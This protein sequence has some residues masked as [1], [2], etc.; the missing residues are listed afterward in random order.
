L[1]G[2]GTPVVADLSGEPMRAALAGRVTV[3]KVSQDERVTHCNLSHPS[4]GAVLDAIYELATAGADHVIVSRGDQPALAMLDG[5]LL[6]VAG[7]HLEAV[8]TRG[9][10]DSF[11]AGVA[12]GLAHRKDICEAVQ[13]G[14]A[15]GSLNVTRRGLATG[16][17][18]EI[19]RLAAGVTVRPMA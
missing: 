13:L 2:N 10:G 17:R 18:D 12:A 14:A 16:H 3:L 1:R 7:P 15:A 19:E 5:Q 9:A 6:S 11:T 8:D 4:A